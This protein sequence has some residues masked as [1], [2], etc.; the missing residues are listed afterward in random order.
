MSDEEGKT[1]DLN[2]IMSRIAKLLAVAED[3]ATPTEAKA[4]Y[5]TKANDLMDKYRKTEEDLIAVD[6]SAVLPQKRV[7][8]VSREDSPFAG[9]LYQLFGRVV[10][11]I[12]GRYR[13]TY[14]QM[15]SG[16]WTISG[17]I[18]AYESDLRYMDLIWS[19]VRLSFI[20]HLEP[21][22]DPDLPEAENIYRLRASGIPRKDVAQMIWG[23]WNH[24]NSAKVGKVYKAECA[25]RGEAPALDGRGIDLKTFRESYA[26]EFHY[27]VVDRL[28]AAEDGS[29]AT[30]GGL[31][32]HGRAERVEEA[33]YNLFPELRPDPNPPAPTI[34]TAEV[35]E[36]KA[37]DRRRKPYHE[38][39]AYR[40]EM[41]RKYNSPAARAGASAGYSA[42]DS[43]NISRTAPRTGRI[44]EPTTEERTIES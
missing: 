22:F 5:L 7:Y 40:R 34:V 3:P 41:H 10:Q 2:K 17:V 21:E 20:A 14:D 39:A 19:S 6:Q 36:E 26:R 4:T 12:G 32:L 44:G 15:E 29:L 11:H 37:V 25:R 38:T 43:V 33:F 13:L 18:V 24:S 28:T 42:G 16:C 30:R 23:F 1:P 31:V 9:W 8:D 27:R 35:K